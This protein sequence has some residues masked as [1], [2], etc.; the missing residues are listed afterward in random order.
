[1]ETTHI[2]RGRFHMRG[3]GFAAFLLHFKRQKMSR[4]SGHYNLT[5]FV[6][7]ELLGGA[8]ESELSA[9]DF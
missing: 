5:S 6:A 9:S 7:T 2:C 4:K 8:A 3:V 1:M